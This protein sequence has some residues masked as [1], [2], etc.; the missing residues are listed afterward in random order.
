[1]VDSKKLVSIIGAEPMDRLLAV[2]GVATANQANERAATTASLEDPSNGTVATDLIPHVLEVRVGISEDG[3]K[4][5][6]HHELTDEEVTRYCPSYLEF[7][8]IG[9]QA[10]RAVAATGLQNG[11]D[12]GQAV[13]LR[14]RDDVRKI[15]AV[16][17]MLENRGIHELQSEFGI[18]NG[19]QQGYRIRG[20]SV[21]DVLEISDTGTA[22]VYDFKTGNA[23]FT[24]STIEQYGEETGEY[25]RL[26][27][28]PYWWRGRYDW[29][30]SCG[31]WR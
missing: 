20:T 9:L 28:Y 27:G 13:H 2:P 17:A 6:F 7:Q 25:M 18:L 26:K 24:K 5:V 15:A 3:G 22:C 23:R 14:A 1:M 19:R 8:D 30:R 31:Q 4:T 10:G 21:L 29:P 12:Y 11:K 16:Q